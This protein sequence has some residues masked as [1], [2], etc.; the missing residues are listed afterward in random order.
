MNPNDPLT[1]LKDIHVPAPVSWWPLAPG[2][3]AVIAVSIILLGL[4]AY[5]LRKR[6]NARR[7]RVQAATELKT[8]SSAQLNN[9]Q[10]VE[11]INAILKRV[12]IQSDK[13]R[14][15]GHLTGRAWLEYLDQTFSKNAD[16]FR[17]GA[18]Q[19]LGEAAY[20]ANPELE[21]PALLSLALRWVKQQKSAANSSRNSVKDSTPQ[22]RGNV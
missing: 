17:E 4:L 12:A 20:Q 21:Q 9:S 8:L 6:Q 7:Y 1:Q 22:E 16:E 15:P 19:A 14:N 11:Q 5:W 10:F 2:W 3:W 18:G 13:R